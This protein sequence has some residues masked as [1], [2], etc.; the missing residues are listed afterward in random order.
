MTDQPKPYL[1]PAPG[2]HAAAQP[3]GDPSTWINLALNE[4][5]Y[6]CSPSVP[7]AV[8]RRLESVY[9]YPAPP[10]PELRGAIAAAFGLDAA[11]ITV[12]NG[13]ED[14]IDNLVRTYCRV[15][16][17]VV[18]PQQSWAGFVISARRQGATP[19][20]VTNKADFIP[21]VDALLAAVTPKTKMML[22]ASPNNPMGS[23]LPAS[24]LRRLRDGLR[25][26]VV[27]VIDS[28]Y[29][30]YVTA[31]DYTA[32]HDLVTGT[33]NVAVTRTFSKCYGLAGART[34]WVHAPKPVIA[35]LNQMRQLSV[36]PGLSEAAAIAALGDK[37]FVS[38]VRDEN[39]LVRDKV[40]AAMKELGLYVVP[41]QTNFI[42]VQFP[43]APGRSAADVHAAVLRD[44]IILLSLA[45]YGLPDYLRITLPTGAQ[46]GRLLDSLHRAFGRN[47]A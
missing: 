9:R 22:V 21:D 34:G 35:A 31:T 20:Q 46:V 14:V 42:A 18:F 40:S 17:E 24:E 39:K 25:Q 27:L 44:G 30:D 23:H 47:A 2:H 4:S 32:G 6:G 29:A 26:D 5:L 38:K 10:A 36:V 28:A 41:S 16:D 12:G 3:G 43:E 15:G 33:P 45:G 8:Q 7:A 11:E 37:A 13:S 1:E 19:V